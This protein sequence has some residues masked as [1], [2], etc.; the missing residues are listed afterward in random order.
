MLVISFYQCLPM[1]FLTFATTNITA[2]Q[3]KYIFCKIG[4]I[5]RNV[6]EVF[7]WP[8]VFKSMGEW[9][10][11]KV[12]FISILLLLLNDS[13]GWLAYFIVWAVGVCDGYEEQIMQFYGNLNKI[14]TILSRICL[15]H[16]NWLNW[17]A[18]E[19]IDGTL[20][21]LYFEFT[22]A[23]GWR[24]KL[25]SRNAI[26]L[27]VWIRWILIKLNKTFAHNP[28]GNKTSRCTS[29]SSDICGIL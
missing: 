11:C 29:P 1:F 2:A 24:R 23:D 15:V 17:M 21:V 4:R 18:D 19:N 8:G 20:F 25:H 7:D 3:A 13:I 26:H 14:V 22:E 10:I 27:K 28:S 6:T 9:N 5:L 12:E 16:N